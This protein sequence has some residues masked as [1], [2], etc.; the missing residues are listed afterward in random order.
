[1]DRPGTGTCSTSYLVSPIGKVHRD[2]EGQGVMEGVPKQDG[3][4]FHPRWS[5]LPFSCLQGSLHGSLAV[6][7]ILTSFTSE[8]RRKYWEFLPLGTLW[9]IPHR[10]RIKANWTGCVDLK[11]SMGCHYIF[12][13]GGSTLV[14]VRG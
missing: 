6:Y 8:N 7:G 10:A 11:T 14:E 9:Y 2:A 12:I 3:H 5:G 1:M 4:H 13:W